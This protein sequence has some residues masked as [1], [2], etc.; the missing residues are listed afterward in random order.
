MWARCT[1]AVYMSALQHDIEATIGISI[2]QTTLAVVLLWCSNTTLH[3]HGI[4]SIII[5]LHSGFRLADDTEFWFL[6]NNTE[7][8]D[9]NLRLCYVYLTCGVWR[10]MCDRVEGL[11]IYLILPAARFNTFPGSD[12][13]TTIYYS[14]PNFVQAGHTYCHTSQLYQTAAPQHSYHSVHRP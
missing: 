1:T 5:R 6:V 8:S 2:Y 11:C 13:T 7:Y 10:V 9:T 4:H 12:N 14:L 3:G